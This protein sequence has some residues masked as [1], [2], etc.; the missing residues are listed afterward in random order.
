MFTA[1]FEYT[2]LQHAVAG[3][4]LASLACGIIGT[5]IV[6]KGY[7][8]MSGG[9]AHTAF[10]GIGLGYFLGIEPIVGALLF[11]T[12]SSV[13]IA[14]IKRKAY[15]NA[16]VL[17]GM[18][19][20]LGMALGVIFIALT[21]GYPPHMTSYLFGDIL[22]VTT[23][24]LMFMVALDIVVL[25]SVLGFYDLI[26]AYL[27]DEEFS[28]A[29]G[30]RMCFTEYLVFILIAITVV[31][32]IRVVG[33]IL[34]LALLCVPPTIG[35]MITYDLRKIMI[36]SIILGTLFCIGGLWISY[37]LGVASGA[38]IVILS[39]SSYAIAL[40]VK[41]LVTHMKQQSDSKAVNQ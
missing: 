15:A 28:T 27:F 9:I 38:S 26:K 29:L 20:P 31:L 22:T 3:A 40:L 1:L 37:M 4:L 33:L 17:V 12:G 14:A 32:M 19:W 11:S 23:Q 24:D 30:L 36:L 10:G 34:I 21:P 2:F 5:I 41:Q 35:R 6:G 16:D 39:V 18:F 8:M 13:A 25:L 7:L